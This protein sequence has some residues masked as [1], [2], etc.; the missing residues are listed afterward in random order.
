M[1]VILSKY[2]HSKNAFKTVLE[3]SEAEKNSFLV[4]S[5]HFL[6]KN[7]LKQDQ[8]LF[9]LVTLVTVV[10]LVMVREP[11]SLTLNVAELLR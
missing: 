9:T 11:L 5:V 10:T 3:R 7:G 4:F 1:T 8:I 2:I 6:V